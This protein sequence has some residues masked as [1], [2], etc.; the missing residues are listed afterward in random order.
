VLFI[1]ADPDRKNAHKWGC[2][3]RAYLID[4]AAKKREAL[5]E[6]PDNGRAW[7]IAWSPDGKKIAYTWTPLDEEILKKDRLTPEDIQKETEGFL[8]VADA[9]GKNPKTVASDKG[10]IALAGILGAIDWR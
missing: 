9:D 10:N 3:Q 1:D 6:F 4:V 5:P 7:G 2:S 8:I